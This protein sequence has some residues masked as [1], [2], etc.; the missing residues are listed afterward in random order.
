MNLGEQGV[1]VREKQHHLFRRRNIV[2]LSILAR[3]IDHELDALTPERVER[4]KANA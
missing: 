3:D 2:N 1:W 4:L